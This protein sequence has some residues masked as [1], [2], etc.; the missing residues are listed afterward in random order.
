MSIG[1]IKG[2]GGMG[3]EQYAT[4][5]LVRRVPSRSRN[6]QASPFPIPKSITL[7]I[8]EGTTSSLTPYVE[9][10]MTEFY[11]PGGIR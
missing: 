5:N 4:A 2:R 1:S 11:Y 9:S 7:D 3:G 6:L 10:A 8:A